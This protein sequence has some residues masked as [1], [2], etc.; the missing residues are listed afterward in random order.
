MTANNSPM[1]PTLF[2]VLFLGAAGTSLLLVA[3]G[4][5]L[6]L[7]VQYVTRTGAS[8]MPRI[9]RISL[10]KREDNGQAEPSRPVRVGP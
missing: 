2:L 4:V 8:P 7:F 5:F 9:P 1:S 10:F 6:S 3:A